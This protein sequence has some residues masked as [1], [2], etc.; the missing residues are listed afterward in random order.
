MR[1]FLFCFLSIII[2]N[3]AW[4]FCP[5]SESL[6]NSL[7]TADALKLRQSC[8]ETQNDDA[9]QVYMARIYENGS[10]DVAKDIK[11]AFYYYQLSSDNGN[12]ESQTRLAQL[13]REYDKDAA[14]R[15]VIKE[16]TESITP[17]LK[18][19]KDDPDDFKGELMH[20]YVLLMLAAEKPENKW[21]Y[22]TNMLVA[23]PVAKQLLAGYKIDAEKKKNLM[24]QATA[25]KKRKLLEIAR[26][27]M[28]DTEY[29]KFTQT[30][31]PSKGKA[32]AFARGQALKAFKEKVVEKKQQDQESAKAFY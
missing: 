17:I 18:T 20:P 19:N 10:S 25:W 13:Y 15:K 2:T 3:P 14:S 12:A 8:A 5:Y 7:K 4:S 31:Y 27:I 11:K 16:Y 9:S 6:L 24:R 29:A 26:Q 28:E 21:Y 22:P 32:D 1:K 30:L 23:P